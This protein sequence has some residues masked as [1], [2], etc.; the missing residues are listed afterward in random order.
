MD[1]CTSRWRSRKLFTSGASGIVPVTHQRNQ[2]GV[3]VLVH[4]GGLLRDRIGQFDQLAPVVEALQPDAREALLKGGGA[5]TA[6]QR[7]ALV[8]DQIEE[9]GA[10]RIVALL[11]AGNRVIDGN[12]ELLVLGAMLLDAVPV[13]A[14]ERQAVAIDNVAVDDLAEG[15]VQA[16]VVLQAERLVGKANLGISDQIFVRTGDLENRGSGQDRQ[17]ANRHHAGHAIGRNREVAFIGSGDFPMGHR[18][19]DR[20]GGEV[21]H[22]R[23]AAEA[24]KWRDH[25]GERNE[26]QYS[27]R[28]EDQL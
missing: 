22:H 8:A 2:V 23:G 28:D 3:I 26:S 7:G 9:F 16:R 13:A 25:S 10:E 19:N 14:G 6:A 1:I 18:E 27:S 17:R 20:E 11:G 24:E 15:F 5:D 12:A 21:G 4:A